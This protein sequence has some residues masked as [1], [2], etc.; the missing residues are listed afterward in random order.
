MGD[1]SA[2][3]LVY[4]SRTSPV[5]IYHL[6]IPDECLY[7]RSRYPSISFTTDGPFDMLALV[8]NSSL[9]YILAF[10]FELELTMDDFCTDCR[11]HFD[12]E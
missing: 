7:G 9:S 5:K 2:R 6:D 10:Q 11:E 3:F 1:L 12:E 8:S 4:S